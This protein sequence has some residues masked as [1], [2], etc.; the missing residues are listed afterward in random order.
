MKRIWLSPATSADRPLF[1]RHLGSDLELGPATPFPTGAD[2]VIVT[3]AFENDLTV[4]AREHR[5]D[6]TLFVVDPPGAA[7]VEGDADDR[8]RRIEA[9]TMEDLAAK[10][11]SGLSLAP[12]TPPVPQ[13]SRWSQTRYQVLAGVAAVVLVVG[14][15]GLI[16]AA[17]H[18]AG[19]RHDRRVARADTVQRFR[20]FQGNG[21]NG[22]SQQIVPFGN[23]GSTNGSTNGN[24]N[25]NSNVPMRQ[26][27]QQQPNVTTSTTVPTATTPAV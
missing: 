2:D 1:E 16:F 18:E 10:I 5:N 4:W 8:V 20:V 19:E 23:N 9:G 12:F 3:S 27:R 22:S 17:G 7:S 6:A 11:R 24:A 21:E 25:G 14:L 15:S 26:F 13:P